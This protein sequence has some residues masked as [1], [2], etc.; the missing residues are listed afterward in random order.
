M[1][2]LFYA[3]KAIDQAVLVCK[4]LGDLREVAALAERASNMYMNHGSADTA[5]SSLDKAAKIL[6]QQN[7]EQALQLFS[8][9]AEIATVKCAC[10]CMHLF[11]G[12]YYSLRKFYS[13]WFIITYFMMYNILF[14]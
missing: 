2:R 11:Y 1:I 9:A 4:E 10:A 13:I 12:F 14:V 3:A 5:A 8:R 6:E 7:P